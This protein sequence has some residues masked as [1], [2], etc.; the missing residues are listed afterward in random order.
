MLLKRIDTVVLKVSDLEKSTE[1]YVN[2]LG[3]R[4]LS[5]ESTYRIFQV[6]EGEAPLTIEQIKDG[7]QISNSRIYPIFYVENIE[8]THEH[9]FLN[10]VHVS[11]IMHDGPNHY[12]EFYDP[13]GNRMQAC[14]WE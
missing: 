14:Y 11:D 3:L 13:D 7:E 10:D 4:L 5:S 2:V 1:W 12:V 6:G 8:K 9:L